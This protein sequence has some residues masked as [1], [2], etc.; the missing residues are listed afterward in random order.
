MYVWLSHTRPC[1][2]MHD[3]HMKIGFSNHWWDIQSRPNIFKSLISYPLI[4]WVCRTNMKVWLTHINYLHDTNTFIHYMF[5]K[6]SNKNIRVRLVHMF[7]NWKLL[8]KNIC[9][10]TC[11]WKSTLKCVKCCLK[12]ENYC[13]KL[14]TKHPLNIGKWCP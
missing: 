12:T 6:K 5:K 4:N 7:K 13:L 3:L 9:G 1:R 8:F 2:G 10:N 11:G 14:L